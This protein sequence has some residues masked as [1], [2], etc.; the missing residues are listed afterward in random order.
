[1]ARSM[2][3][4]GT[5]ISASIVT[6]PISPG[7]PGSGLRIGTGWAVYDPYSPLPSLTTGGGATIGAIPHRL[8][9]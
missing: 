5:A 6:M 3:S 4:S 2:P 7:L 8:R 1:M 9:R